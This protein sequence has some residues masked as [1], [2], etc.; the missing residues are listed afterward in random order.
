MDATQLKT[1]QHICHIRFV[2]AEAKD[3]GARCGYDTYRRLN[4]ITA[5]IGDQKRRTL[6]RVS[7]IL[8]KKIGRRRVV[9][10]VDFV[11]FLT[12]VIILVVFRV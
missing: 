12:R 4:A 10:F 7:L 11:H 1:T 5:R 9:R 3:L 6:L 2:V 8:A